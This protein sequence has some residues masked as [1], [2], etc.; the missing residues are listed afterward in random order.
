VKILALTH[1]LPWAPNRGDRIRAY[2]VLHVLRA[3]HDLH[4][5]SLVHDEEEESH[6]GEVR[7]W[8]SGVSTI[9]VHRARNLA[10][11]AFALPTSTP[12]TFALLDAPALRPELH[13]L[14]TRVRPD[15]VFAYCSGMARLLTDPVVSSLPS[16]V[17]MVDMDSAKWQALG[18]TT[19]GPVGWVYAREARVLSRAEAAQM[20]HARFTTVV[21]SREAQTAAALAPDADIRIVQNGVD[22][23]LF[24]P[25][26]GP[27][28]AR[29]V[30]FCGVMSYRPNAETALWLAERVWPRVRTMHPDARLALVGSEPPEPLKRLEGT[31]P[32]VVVTGHVADV[33]SWLWESAVAAAPIRTAR[34][35]QNKVLEAIAAGLPCVIS[36]AVAQG[37]PAEVMPACDIADD[38]ESCA[39]RIS[40]LLGRSPEERRA[41]ARMAVLDGLG[42]PARLQP[43]LELFAE[44]DH[45]R[46]SATP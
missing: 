21:N 38:A 18:V 26:G 8:L 29:Q 46:R 36:S 11:A 1:R 25:P 16:I 10:R 44:L 13:A 32:S 27:A 30:V 4:L 39:D 35:I 31:D 7:T 40:A 3:R 33:R 17:D 28:A 2:H 37:L 19:S 34:G 42:W 9:R 22:V 12:L 23:A 6:V 43:M 5:L 24:S 15:A 14:V 20:R 45:T 41:R